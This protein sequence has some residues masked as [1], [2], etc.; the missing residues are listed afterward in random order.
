[1]RHGSALSQGAHTLHRKTNKQTFWCIRVDIVRIN[2]SF[3]GALGDVL[4]KA[5]LST[6]SQVI[7]GRS[8][9]PLGDQSGS[10]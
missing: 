6:E 4:R 2:F 9:N 3:G 5:L 1:M 8:E 10:D 7:T